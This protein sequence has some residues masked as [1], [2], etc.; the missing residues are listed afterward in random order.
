MKRIVLLVVFL[1]VCLVS[2]S[3][4]INVCSETEIDVSEYTEEIN[5]FD[6]WNCA[7]SDLHIVG[8]TTQNLYV[9]VK[10]RN[11]FIDAIIK[12]DILSLCLNDGGKHIYIND[13]VYTEKLILKNNCQNIDVEG[14]LFFEDVSKQSYSTVKMVVDGEITIG[15]DIFNDKYYKGNFD[16]VGSSSST[17]HICKNKTKNY[18]DN[19]IVTDG[20]VL[21]NEAEYETDP[22][23][24]GD[25]NYNTYGRTPTL[26]KAYSGFET[27]MENK[28][29]I[30]VLFINEEEKEPQ[31]TTET[32]EWPNIFYNT[33]NHK[34]YI[35]KY[36]GN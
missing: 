27:C 33:T 6:N 1:F 20:Y 19:L 7:T 4:D 35:K 9:D 2:F 31:D 34:F 17:F 30:G 15:A 26:I 36:I 10:N 12:N 3:V 32:F 16:V 25:V 28:V 23:T 24:E 5:I 13:L 21:Y 29:D 8:A 18:P 14:S 11:V 22:V